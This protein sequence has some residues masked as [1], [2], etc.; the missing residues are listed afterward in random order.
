MNKLAA[1]GNLKMK[2][3]MKIEMR[4]RIIIMKMKVKMILLK[5]L[6]FFICYS[7]FFNRQTLREIICIRHLIEP[8]IRRRVASGG[9]LTNFRG[10]SLQSTKT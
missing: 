4:T 1:N 10:A 5:Y 3:K 7:S 9:C 8:P 2:T 6:K